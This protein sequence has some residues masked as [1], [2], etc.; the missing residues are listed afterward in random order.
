MNKIIRTKIKATGGITPEGKA[1]LGHGWIL[2]IEEQNDDKQRDVENEV[3]D[4]TL[5]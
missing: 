2:E 4:G 3:P 1:K 5:V